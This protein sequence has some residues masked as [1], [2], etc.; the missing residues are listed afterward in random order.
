MSTLTALLQAHTDTVL[1]VTLL[2]IFILV[3]Y[4]LYLDHKLSKFTKGG[5]GASL[6]DTIAGCITQAT[7][8]EKRNEILSE[9]ILTLEEKVSHALRNAQTVRYKAFD[10]N[11]SNQSFSLALVNEKGNGV[12]ISTL[13]AHERISTFAKPVEQYTSTYELTDEEKQ[14]LDDAKKAH[15]TVRKA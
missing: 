12:I 13:H 14:V 2:C 6:E 10:Q 7:E 8:I 1:A 5:T 9:H 3:A 11:G 15:K 4:T